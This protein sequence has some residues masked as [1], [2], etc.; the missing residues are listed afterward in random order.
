ML[1]KIIFFLFFIFLITPVYADEQINQFNVYIMVNKDASI[2]IT[3][4]INVRAEGNRIKH[5]LVRR[6]PTQYVDSYNIFRNTD[7]QIQKILLNN[8]STPYHLKNDNNQLQVYIGS[9]NTWLERGDYV[10]TINYHVN[11]AVNFLRDNDEVYWNITG[12]NWDFPIQR[13]QATIYL[14]DGAMISHGAA[15]SGEK[16]MKGQDFLINYPAKNIMEVATTKILNPGEGLTVAAAWQKG[17]VIQPT[18]WERILQKLKIGDYLAIGISILAFIY[19]YFIWYRKGRD[20]RN[21]SI[22]P[23]F[24]PPQNLSPEAMRFIRRMGFDMKTFTA[25]IVNMAT[26]GYLNIKNEEK[27]FTLTKNKISEIELPL[28]ERE[29]ADN[30][31]ASRD[32]IKLSKENYTT[33]SETKRKFKFVLNDTYQKRYFIS[34]FE[35]FIYGILLTSLAFAAV[36]FGSIDSQSTGFMMCWLF[37]WTIGC[38]MLLY[39]AWLAIQEFSAYKSVVTFG[40]V[41]FTSLFA[42]P[43]L[44]GEIVGFFALTPMVSLITLLFLILIT[45]CNVIF[46]FLLK[47]PTKEG[48]A[49]MDQIDGFRLYLS[50]TERYR[51][52]SWNAPAKTPELFE[53]YLPYAIA[54][55]VENEWGQQF[56][57][58]LREAGIPPDKYRPV[59]YTGTTSWSGSNLATA[60]P[61]ILAT[62]LASSL[63]SAST[64]SSG[65]G[66]GGS[67]GGGGGGGGGG[68][69]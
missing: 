50:T 20:L 48:R 22:I 13:A 2:D 56:N 39:Q 55:N 64:S 41:I 16:G 27:E 3:E 9:Q 34:N 23:L 43:F 32:S 35:Y 59:W 7:Y 29:I 31:F 67:S 5:G 4:Y 62:G 69:W 61:V 19:Y 14:P 57:E 42:V 25:A 15:Y 60:L 36:I 54:L 33:L 66:G 24:E 11:D 38:G 44:I 28:E 37:I 46:Y 17:I 63:A 6:L 12:N 8:H 47:A 68:G 21:N 52:N 45:L 51:L 40:K 1:K 58:V 18:F 30:L 10:Y 49:L 53:K 65:S 26:T